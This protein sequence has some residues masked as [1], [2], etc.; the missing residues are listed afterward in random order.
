MTISEP[1]SQYGEICKSAIQTS[2]KESG[3]KVAK[4][5]EKLLI[6][7]L[8]LYMIL[9]RKIN[10]TQ[11]ARYG[12]H[13]EQ[14]YRRNFN[15]KRK[16]CIDWLLFNLS[17]AGRVLD[18]TDLLVIAIDPSYI[19]KAGNKTPHIGR[20][21]SGCAGA[22]KHGL[23]IMGIGLVAVNQNKCMMLRAHQTLGTSALKMRDKTQVEYYI[24]VMKRYSKKLLSITDIVVADAF[25]S[26]STFEK[27]IT[28]LGYHLVSRFRDN[29]CLHYL[30][31]GGRTGRR[32]RPKILDGKIDLS[33]P[34]YSRMERLY[35]DGLEGSA[36]TL[37]A[38]AKA[39]KKKVRLVI[40]RMPNGKH[41]LFFST[42]LSMTGE[43][44][45]KAYRSRFQIEFEFRNGKQFAGLMDCQARHKEQLDF[46]FNASLASVNVSKVFIK[47]NGMDN[48]IAQVK[49]LMF[50]AYYTKAIFDV[51]RL[52]PNRNLIGR[53]FKELI[54]WKPKAA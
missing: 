2:V 47:D 38:Y 41:K 19:S 52:R 1:L 8:T 28:E 14:T 36:Y 29:A 9:P 21:W 51:S 31:K 15:R 50:N 5:F 39:M 42:K 11:M 40:W 30:Y 16:K 34:D 4:T 35:I 53:I 27:G 26:T 45:L 54:G 6:E 49:S 37:P 20:F 32:G 25:F 33:R 22:V 7:I 17:L 23:E 46:A 18:M 10:F 43:E 13:C 44:V 3:A 12:K 24:S 48:S